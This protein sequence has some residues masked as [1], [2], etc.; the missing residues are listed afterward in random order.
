MSKKKILIIAGHVNITN[1]AFHSM[2]TYVKGLDKEKYDIT[3]LMCKSGIE[4]EKIKDCNVETKIIPYCSCTVAANSNSIIKKIIKKVINY[5]LEIKFDFWF[6]KKQFDL[7]H[8][9][10]STTSFGVKTSI[11]RQVPIIWHFREFLEEDVNLTYI[12]KKEMIRLLN[13]AKICISITDAVALFF[14]NNYMVTKTKTI[15]NG[16]DIIPRF[17]ENIMDK[18]DIIFTLVGRI[19][20]QKGQLEAIKA[21]NKLKRDFDNI[22]LKIVG[23]IGDNE[24]YED[25]CKYLQEN[26]L[27]N[28]VELISHQ[29]D[30]KKIWDCTDIALICSKKEGFGRVTAEFMLNGI[31]VIGSA[32]GGTVE[33]LSENKGILYE[34]GNVN[35]LHQKMSYCIK[36]PQIID[37]IRKKA[38]AFASSNFT[39]K[40]YVKKIEEVYD[41]VIA[42]EKI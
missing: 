17:K 7:V 14:K 3:V 21:F 1:G 26:N 18:K 41:A 10:V 30:L 29:K 28:C 34:Y 12:D 23:D 36:N 15:Y 39:S 42:K 40:C 4:E 31:P 9:N 5:F 32:T 11:K 22:K 20:T 6:N 37:K 35:D 13:K 24:Y 25:I 19:V 33:L 16:I 38:Y 8:I 2:L 27:N